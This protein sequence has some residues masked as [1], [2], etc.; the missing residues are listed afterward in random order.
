M[1]EDEIK[2]DVLPI[3]PI[4]TGL[5]PSG[6]LKKKVKC[7]VFD[8]YGTLFVSGSGDIGLSK[9]QSKYP[10][11]LDRLFRRFGIQRATPEILEKYFAA[12]EQRHTE[13]KQK[14]IDYPEVEIDRI[15]MKV[16]GI[17]DR[18]QARALAMAFEKTVNP[19]YPM[20]HLKKMLTACGQRRIPLGII[21][22]AQ[23]YTPRLFQCFLGISPEKLGFLPDLTFYSYRFGRAKPSDVLFRLAAEKMA[24]RGISVESTLYVGNDMLN[25]VYPAQG[26]GFKTALFAGDARS[27]RLRQDHPKCKTLASD[28]VVTDLMQLVDWI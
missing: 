13:I 23:F 28:L 7:L 5:K 15:W 14:G 12:I 22:N 21:S 18:D 11:Q 9:A 17:G 8:I 3:I 24:A 1:T 27:L 19:V 4:P 10:P 20:V 6:M 26:I 2:K 16:L 25:D